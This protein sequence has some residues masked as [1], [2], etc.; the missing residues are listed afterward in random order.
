MNL[1]GVRWRPRRVADWCTP[2]IAAAIISLGLSCACSASGQSRTGDSPPRDLPDRGGRPAAD[3]SG[4]EAEAYRQ[5]L[6]NLKRGNWRDAADSF[7]LFQ[8]E[9]PQHDKAAFAELYIARANLGRLPPWRQEDTGS[10]AGRPPETPA[11]DAAGR[12]RRMQAISMLGSLAESTERMGIDQAA[13]M[14]LVYAL[15]RRLT[16]AD[17]SDDDPST[18][19]K[20]L[21]RHLQALERPLSVAPILSMDRPAVLASLLHAFESVGGTDKGRV[22]EHRV[23]G[24]GADRTEET[25]PRLIIE[26]ADRLFAAVTESK[27]TETALTAPATGG[28][29]SREA[30]SGSQRGTAEAREEE[31]TDGA[32]RKRS[33]AET[34]EAFE[35]P[36]NQ[37]DRMLLAYARQMAFEAAESMPFPDGWTWPDERQDAKVGRLARAALGWGRSIEVLNRDQPDVESHQKLL[38]RTTVALRRVGATDRASELAVHRITAGDA[39][40]MVLAAVVPTS[41]PNATIGQRAVDG[42]M[43]GLDVFEGRQASRVTIQVV[44]ATQSVSTIGRRLDQIGASIVIGPLDQNRA[45]KLA[46]V[47][48]QKDIPMMPMTTQPVAVD[49]PEESSLIL[50][51]FLDPPAE[52]R[53]AARAAF[54]RR[55][56]RSIAIVHPDNGYGRRMRDT[57]KEE[58][59][60]LG[61]RI[62]L[63]RAYNRKTSD[64]SSLASA[65]ATAAPDGIFI[66]GAASN[67]AEISAFIAQENTWG[68]TPNRTVE[69]RRGGQRIDYIGT[70]LW[71]DSVLPRQAGSY[72]G[73]PVIPAW[74]ARGLDDE[75]SRRFTRRFESAFDGN[76]T[77]VEA[78]AYDAVTW[79]RQF[80]LRRG[81]RRPVSLMKTLTSDVTLEGAT[82]SVR[83][84]QNHQTRSVR[85][86]TLSKTGFN[87]MGFAIDV[88][89]K[90]VTDRED[91]RRRRD[92][93]S[94]MPG[95]MSEEGSEQSEETDT[96]EPTDGSSPTGDTRDE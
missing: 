76:A 43:L 82:G 95:T 48:N 8:S 73:E 64:Y 39:G 18:D 17:G 90:S 83:F 59:R 7:R 30:E 50:R 6:E 35:H 94:S 32:D 93:P 49:A 56:N 67:V 77:N 3:A 19:A 36:E 52:A 12:E 24:K 74:Y 31:S 86:L 84:S 60:N 66:P 22:D 29:T 14:Y 72:L 28:P 88:E 26:A 65:V 25:R 89:L 16:P 2:A 57:F 34:M 81:I 13:R 80:V 75:E 87:P 38:D 42:M 40:P 85:F 62:V 41:G 92:V 53:V 54:R 47:V 1:D 11:G 96:G 21:N 27:P 71:V 79:I 63:E 78:F 61:G 55:D 9:H 23:E 46:A 91:S 33:E 37:T 15:N 44:D 51:N 10:S 4:P 45:D 70:S 5:G 58:F 69:R 20:E 68:R